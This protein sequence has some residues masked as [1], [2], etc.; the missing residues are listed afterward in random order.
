MLLFDPWLH[1][2]IANE[3]VPF[4]GYQ[5]DV[6]QCFDIFAHVDPDQGSLQV[7]EV[8]IWQPVG[9]VRQ[10]LRRYHIVYVL[11]VVEIVV[12][13]SDVVCASRV[14]ARGPRQ[15]HLLPERKSI[16]IVLKGVVEDLDAT[17]SE[18]VAEAAALV[19]HSIADVTPLRTSFNEDCS[20]DLW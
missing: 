9:E 12:T 2:V 20:L 1:L 11:I 16:L 18:E 10:L 15:T 7:R 8:I 17:L 19:G 5:L 6:S 4:N 13:Y 3:L 14:D